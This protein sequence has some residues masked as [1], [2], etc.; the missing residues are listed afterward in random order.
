MNEYRGFPRPIPRPG[1]RVSVTIG[2]SISDKI[3][4]LVERW[5]AIAAQE[6]GDLGVGGEWRGT[7]A[8]LTSTGSGSATGR[9]A[10]EAEDRRQRDVR[11]RGIL[12]GS[13]EEAIR[14]EITAA[15]QEEVRKLGERVESAEGR[16]E[17]G[18]WSQSRRSED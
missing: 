8:S 5:R 4:P 1:G 11:S 16:F 10:E 2:E 12:A 3:Q 18:E 9:E 14:I 13:K 7:D 17:R 15:I 6:K